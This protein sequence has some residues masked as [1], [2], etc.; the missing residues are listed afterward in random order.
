MD[1]QK[2]TPKRLSN[3]WAGEDEVKKN[4]RKIVISSIG[5]WNIGYNEEATNDII[6]V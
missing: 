4:Y 2:K 5:L 3:V 1:W 6:Q